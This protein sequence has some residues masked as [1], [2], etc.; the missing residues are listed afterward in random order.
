MSIHQK[1]TKLSTDMLIENIVFLKDKIENVEIL[2]ESL[3]NIGIERISGV[4][5]LNQK[6]IESG[7]IRDIKFSYQEKNSLYVQDFNI[8]FKKLFYLTSLSLLKNLFFCAFAIL[9]NI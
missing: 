4:E 6:L 2:I 5:N 1:I 7:K 3:K 8:S 9:F